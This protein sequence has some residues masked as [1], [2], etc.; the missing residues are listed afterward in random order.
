MGLKLSLM[1]PEHLRIYVRVG[2]N[3]FRVLRL[4]EIA[5]KINVFY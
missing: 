5:E 2:G 4:F 1:M 3:Y